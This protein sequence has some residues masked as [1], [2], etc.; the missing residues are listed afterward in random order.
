MAAPP[1]LLHRLHLHRPEQVAPRLAGVLRPPRPRPRHHH[2]PQRRNHGERCV[3]QRLREH[4]PRALGPPHPLRRLVRD[5]RHE[6]RHHHPHALHV[7]QLRQ[8]R[9]ALR[10]HGGRVPGPLVRASA[11]RHL[12]QNLAHQLLGHLQRPEQAMDVGAL[13]ELGPPLRLSLLDHHLLLPRALLVPRRRHGGHLAGDDYVRVGLLHR[14]RLCPGVCQ[15][16]DV[17]GARRRQPHRALHLCDRRDAR[18]RRARGRGERA[19]GG[20]GRADGG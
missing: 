13:P 20:G 8:A 16:C 7:P 19:Q 15:D 9:L 4:R 5:W 10:P 14:G 6:P 12:P 17:A 11:H 3:R 18:G 1:L 2:H